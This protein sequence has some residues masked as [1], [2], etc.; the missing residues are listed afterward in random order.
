MVPGDRDAVCSADKAN[1]HKTAVQ[2]SALFSLGT[3]WI[4]SHMNVILCV[5]CPQGNGRIITERVNVEK[6]DNLTVGVN[7]PNLVKMTADCVYT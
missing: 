7:F 3:T 1:K 6:S 4:I 2:S 5:H